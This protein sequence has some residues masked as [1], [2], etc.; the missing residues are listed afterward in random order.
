MKFLITVGSPKTQIPGLALQFNTIGSGCLDGVQVCKLLLE[1]KHDVTVLTPDVDDVVA[2]CPGA[3][4]IEYVGVESLRVLME[5]LANNVK[6]DAIAHLADVP[7]WATVRSYTSD[8]EVGSFGGEAELYEYQ[9]KGGWPVHDPWLRLTR[10]EDDDM[11]PIVDLMHS[12]SMTTDAM[13]ICRDNIFLKHAAE[14]PHERVND[15]IKEMKKDEVDVTIFDPH[16]YH[17]Q[18]GRFVGWMM[19]HFGAEQ[20]DSERMAH[21]VYDALVM[22][23][24]AKNE[25]VQAEDA[26][27]SED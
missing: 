8:Q 23:R 9:N 20:M 12:L 16:L 27:N 24:G 6:Y 2:A 26:T 22:G 1:Q 21:A 13:L 19:G 5:Y 25:E 4:V 11:N 15:R 7:P 10:I 17:A 14:K 18:L 3:R